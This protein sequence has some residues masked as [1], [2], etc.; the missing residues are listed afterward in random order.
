[1]TLIG[2]LYIR[3]D[4]DIDPCAIDDNLIAYPQ[5]PTY[6]HNIT[7][8]ATW[9]QMVILQGRPEFLVIGGVYENP[10]QRGKEHIFQSVLYRARF[11]L[12]KN[13]AYS[14]GI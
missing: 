6:C 14:E 8:K 10:S 7:N 11:C 12:L 13:S 5:I 9:Y 1:M 4:P 2:S 3:N